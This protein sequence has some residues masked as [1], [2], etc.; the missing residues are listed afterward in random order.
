MAKGGNAV[1]GS[2]GLGLG[3]L[4]CGGPP[5]QV[6]LRSGRD[7]TLAQSRAGRMCVWWGETTQRLSPFTFHLLA[8]PPKDQTHAE[9]WGQESK[10]KAE[11]G[12]GADKQWGKSPE[13]SLRNT[14]L[15][16]AGSKLHQDSW[17][18]RIERGN[19][20]RW[21]LINILKTLNSALGTEQVPRY[22]LVVF[23][24]REN[25]VKGPGPEAGDY[26]GQGKKKK[27]KK[28]VWLEWSELVGN[29]SDLGGWG[30]NLIEPPR[31]L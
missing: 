2:Q 18:T 8:L 28:P 1:T 7:R 9:A 6:E 22:C 5:P 20:Y 29:E 14:D 21:E 27:K 17:S 15:K 23:P 13:S 30:A 31:L 26:F 24:S 3:E 11:N 10:R 12:G 16:A 19:T 4:E 25:K